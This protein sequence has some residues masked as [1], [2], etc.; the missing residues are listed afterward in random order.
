MR[1]LVE[2]NMH[3][4]NKT[5]VHA[6]LVKLFAI[7]FTIPHAYK[8]QLQVVSLIKEETINFLNI[9]SNCKHVYFQ[10]S[11]P[12]VYPKPCY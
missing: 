10:K 5:L 6:K 3:V 4:L 11:N 8:I 2:G 1:N 12:Y 9:I 7:K